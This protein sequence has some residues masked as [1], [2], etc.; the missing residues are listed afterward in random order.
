MD[1]RLTSGHLN[2]NE[3]KNVFNQ[4]IELSVVTVPCVSI[5]LLFSGR[6]TGSTNHA[7]IMYPKEKIKRRTRL[8]VDKD[9]PKGWFKGNWKGDYSKLCYFRPL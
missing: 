3:E 4:N 8:R 2:I 9:K 5:K 6:V 7:I 1:P